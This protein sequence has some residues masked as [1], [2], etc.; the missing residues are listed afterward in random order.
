MPFCFPLFF[1]EFCVGKLECFFV[2]AIT[3]LFQPVISPAVAP[4]HSLRQTFVFGACASKKFSILKIFDLFPPLASFGLLMKTKTILERP[5]KPEYFM[6]SH[7][8]LFHKGK[9]GEREE[10]RF[11]VC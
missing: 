9:R 3:N 8:E 5:L 10:K 6:L 11:S 1:R 2:S 4:S 7:R